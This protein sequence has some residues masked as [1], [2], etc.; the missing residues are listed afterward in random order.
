[1][2]VYSKFKIISQDK[3]QGFLSNL[4]ERTSDKSQPNPTRTSKPLKMGILTAKESVKRKST[5]MDLDARSL[6]QSTRSR[7]KASKFGNIINI[8]VSEVSVQ[9]ENKMKFPFSSTPSAISASNRGSFDRNEDHLA[10][11]LDETGRT[12]FGVIELEKG[13]LTGSGGK[14]DQV[15]QFMA[16]KP[17]SDTRKRDSRQGKRTAGRKISKF[18]ISNQKK[19]ATNKK[20]SKLKKSLNRSGSSRK[21]PFLSNL[22]TTT[23]PENQNKGENQKISISDFDEIL[24]S[25]KSPYSA[26]IVGSRNQPPGSK[27]TGN[28]KRIKKRVKS[29]AMR[30]KT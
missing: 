12:P 11:Y 25:N 13:L 3:R 18:S 28:R 30:F 7:S 8:E 9:D 14:Y 20:V 22:T 24:R 21:S 4:C 6:L 29:R 15:K 17:S 10:T 27:V 1:M 2:R 26:E 23:F 19:T 5:G 16:K